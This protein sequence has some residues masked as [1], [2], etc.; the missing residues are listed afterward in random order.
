MNQQLRR[1]LFATGSLLC[2]AATLKAQTSTAAPAATA[3]AT[4]AATPTPIAV[5]VLVDGYYS[6]NFNNPAGEQNQL[7]NFNT[8]ANS[9][10]LELAEF[11]AT[12][13]TAKP[14]DWGFTL[15]AGL[16][17]TINLVTASDPSGDTSTKNLLQAYGTYIAPIGKGLQLDFGKFVTNAGAEVIETNANWNYSHSIL[18]GYAIPYFHTGLRATYPVSGKLSLWGMV[19]NGWNNVIDNNAGKTF[20]GG[21][22]YTP[23]SKISL[24]ENLYTGPEQTNDNHDYR[25]LTDTVL[26]LTPTGKFSYMLNYDYGSDTVAGGKVHWDGIAAYTRFALNSRVA[27]TPRVEWYNDPQGFTTGTAQ[28]LEELTITPEFKIN[29]NILTRAEYRIDHSNQPFFLDHYGVPAHKNQETATL[30]VIFTWSK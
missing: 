22:T 1:L 6:G 12:R 29:D 10:G 26:T 2:L 15:V 27:L 7:Y 3:A 11:K 16:G 8:S 28:K 23:S 24:V 14:G 9:F 17:N 21:F 5:S 20:G 30:G 18:F 25:K 19:A 13:A 4:P